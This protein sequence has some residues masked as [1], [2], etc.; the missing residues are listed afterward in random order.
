MSPPDQPLQR[1]R[2]FDFTSRMTEL[3]QDVAARV[4]PLAHVEMAR[5]AVSAAQTRSAVQHGLWASLTPL[6]FRDGATETVRGGRRFRMP[7]ILRTDGSEALYIL[8]FYLPRFLMLGFRDRVTTV[9][10]ELWHVSPLFDGDIRRFPGRCYAHSGSKDAFDAQAE[11]L[12]RLYLDAK[13]DEELLQVCRL[14]FD[15]LR[16]RHGRVFGTRYRQPRL[17]PVPEND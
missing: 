10:H 16:R 7:R 13:P 11:D 4:A 3:C 12:A 9:C 1:L 8:T 6:R 14:S 17:I 15:E 2:G 5:I